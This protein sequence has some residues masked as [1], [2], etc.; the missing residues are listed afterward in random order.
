MAGLERGLAAHPA[1]VAIHGGT[2]LTRTLLA[3]ECRLV[4]GIPAVVVE[5]SFDRDR[6]LR[7]LL[8]GRADAVGIA[9]AALP[10]RGLVA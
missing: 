10:G 9:A 3:E 2:S 5:E 6:A 4:R 1:L 7:L 8:S